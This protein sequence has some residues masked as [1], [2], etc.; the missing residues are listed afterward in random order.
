MHGIIKS[1]NAHRGYG[2]IEPLIG[3][4]G[5]RM[6]FFHVST[7]RGHTA[8]I[9]TRVSFS[10]VDGPKGPQA[11]DVE[12]RKISGQALWPVGNQTSSQTPKEK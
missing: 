4:P 9:G 2:F 10:L 7:L 8:P 1:F 5:A 12:L 11:A 3:K 6:V